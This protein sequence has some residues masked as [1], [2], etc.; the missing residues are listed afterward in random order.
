MSA[1]LYGLVPAFRPWAHK[2]LVVAS[3]A[4]FQ[5]RV[6]STRRSQREQSFLYRQSLAGL[7]PFPVAPP[8]QSAHQAGYALDLVTSPFSGLKELGNLWREWGGIWGPG[9]PVHFEFPGYQ[10]HEGSPVRGSR[11]RTRVGR[12]RRTVAATE[13]PA[14]ASSNIAWQAAKTIGSLF[15]PTPLMTKDVDCKTFIDPTDF[16]CRYFSSLFCC[17]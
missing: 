12:T 17:Q 4:G 13:P 10:G 6:T 8:G 16:R 5:P 15:V 7:N 11:R 3:R 2:L 9:D 1:S 14:G